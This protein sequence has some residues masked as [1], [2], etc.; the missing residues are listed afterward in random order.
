MG[1]SPSFTVRPLP[2]STALDGAFRVHIT[3][4][5]LELL[6]LKAGELCQLSSADGSTGVGIAWRST[7]LNVKP[8]VHP[9]KVTDTLRDAYGFKLGNQLTLQK[10]GTKIVR[11]DRIVAI[12]V[13]DSH[14]IDASKDDNNWKLRCAYT[15]GNITPQGPLHLE[16]I[17]N[18]LQGMS[19]PLLLALLSKLPRARGSRSVFWLNRSSQALGV[20]IVYLHLMIPLSLF[21]RMKLLHRPHPHM[22]Y[23]LWPSLRRV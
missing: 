18:F 17:T 14:N 15:L 23:V 13:T 12:D 20:A 9:I 10:A 6:G 16:L 22:C 1:D 2:P 8:G 21:Y 4:K 11:A 3:V 19:K 7:D 5:D